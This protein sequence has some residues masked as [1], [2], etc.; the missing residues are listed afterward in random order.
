MPRPTKRT[1]KVEELD[2]QGDGI[3]S[4]LLSLLS[5][6]GA[7]VVAVIHAFLEES[8]TD[9]NASVAGVACFYGSQ[10]QWDSFQKIWKPA[11]RK[12]SLDAGW[13][14]ELSPALS[15]AIEASRLDG[16]LCTIS[17]KVYMQYT[18]EELKSSVGNCYATCTFICA[19]AISRQVNHEPVS[20]VLEQGQPNLALVKRILEAMIDAGE[21]SIAAVTSA[22]KRDFLQ[23]HAADFMSHA[24]SSQDL[25]WMQRLLHAGRL[26]LANVTAE[27]LIDAA[28]Q[29]KTLI[30]RARNARHAVNRNR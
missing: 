6:N 29:V 17:K 11:L 18:R 12:K 2:G 22:R 23:L 16:L 21:G 30:E 5:G 26:R 1:N 19:L 15:R 3:G 7:R 20:I 8:G 25:A 10:E 24:A 27:M 14:A 28:Q 9:G 13:T 4:E